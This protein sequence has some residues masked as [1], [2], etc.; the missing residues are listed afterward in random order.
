MVSGTHAGMEP[1]TELT[2]HRMGE[3][4]RSGSVVV[5]VL[6]LQ[7]DFAEHAVALRRVGA[8][9]H[10]VRTAEHLSRVDGLIIPGGE[11]T[12]IARLMI[13]Y[14]LREPIIERGRAGL[15]IWG[16]CAGAILLAEEIVTLDRPGLHLVPMTVERNAFGRQIDSFEADVAPGELGGGPLHAIFIRAPRIRTVADGVDVLLRLG[17]EQEREPVAVQYGSLMATTFHP[18]L[19]EDGR[20]HERFV[21]LCAEYAAR[22]ALQPGLAAAGGSG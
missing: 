21:G 7:G 12:T 20:L 18:E 11:S 13:A 6:A 15:P 2:A 22:V 19:T 17:P 10:E 14:E 3:V 9:V 16:T 5:G 8:E 1:V 4:G